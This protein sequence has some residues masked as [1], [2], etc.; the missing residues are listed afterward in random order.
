MFVRNGEHDAP[1]RL[2][3]DVGV[4]VIEQLGHHDVAALDQAQRV[5]MRHRRHLVQERHRPWPGRIGQCA[6]LHGAAAAVAVFEL[7][8]PEPGIAPGTHTA[9][10]GVDLGAALGGI[11]RIEHHQARVLHPGIGIDEAGAQRFLQRLPDRVCAQ[12]Q[13]ARARQAALAAAKVV[14]QEQA[15]ADHPGRAQMRLMRQQKAQRPDDVRGQAQQHFALGQCLADQRELVLLQIAQPT[16][17]QLGAGATGMRGKIVLLAETHRQ[18]APGR[19][20]GDADPVDAAAYHQKIVRL[21]HRY[22]RP[23][24]L[25]SEPKFSCSNIFEHP[26]FSGREDVDALE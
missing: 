6:R 18:T 7:G 11:H 19:I 14:V 20:A 5:L 13:P 12:R 10:A 3:E 8:V 23:G 26:T 15:G 16:M 17:D 22:L 4:I 2:L 25:R 1:V 9:R 21:A 24:A